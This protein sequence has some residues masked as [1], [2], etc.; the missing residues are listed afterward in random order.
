MIYGVLAVLALLVGTLN[1]VLL[2][3]S[4]LA[5]RSRTIAMLRCSGASRGDIFRM[6]LSETFIMIVA[7]ILLAAFLL[8]CLS[9]HI[10]QLLGYHLNELFALERIWI[11]AL[12]C[13]VSFLLAGLI[14]AVLYSR[15]NLEY[16]FKRGSDNRT[17]WK[18]ILLFV[19]VA[20]TTAVVCFLLVTAQQSKYVLKADVG[21]KYDNVIT[22]EYSAT[23]SQHSALS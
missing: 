18:R 1:Y 11:P 15:V 8:L 13:I 14:P 20:C 23:Q 21:Y 16:A 19:Q 2:T 22:M 3:L 12:V 9:N 6:L 10:Y 7:S 5:S 4:S 17:W